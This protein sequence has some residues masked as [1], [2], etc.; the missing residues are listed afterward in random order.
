VWDLRGER[1]SF[2][3][4]EGHKGP[5]TCASFSA[6]GTHVVTAP[7]TSA[8]RIRARTSAGQSARRQARPQ[9]ET[10]RPS[11]AR[12]A[13]RRRDLDGEPVREIARSY[14]VSHNTICRLT[15]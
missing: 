14:N 9:T 1:P 7:M 15:A 5:V 4:L 11:E 12:G 2:A 13:I 8:G 10:D 3:V 6:D